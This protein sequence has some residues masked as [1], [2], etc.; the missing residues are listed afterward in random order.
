MAAAYRLPVGQNRG[1]SDRYGRAGVDTRAADRGVSALVGVL[2]TIDTGRASRSV[3]ASGHYAAVLEIAP[4]LGIACA[5]TA[6][7]PS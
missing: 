4:N 7:A 1:V 6:S 5:P 2:Q 3:L